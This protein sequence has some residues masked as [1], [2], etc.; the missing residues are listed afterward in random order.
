MAVAAAAFEPNVESLT[1]RQSLTTLTTAVSGD[2]P[3]VANRCCEEGLISTEQLEEA[4]QQKNLYSRANELVRRAVD[5]V[6]LDPRKFQSFLNILDESGMF[7]SV[8]RDVRNKYTKNQ[9]KRQVNIS[10][11]GYRL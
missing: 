11:D 2:L 5:Q 6:T 9:A 4:H 8:V 1:L 7:E 3:R 10:E